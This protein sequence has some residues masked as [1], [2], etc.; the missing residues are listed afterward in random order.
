MQARTKLRK[1]RNWAL[2]KALELLKEASGDSSTT[3]LKWEGREVTVNG[4]VA[5]KQLPGEPKGTFQNSFAHL[6]LP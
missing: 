6:T 2:K 1:S 3:E 5:F 4:A